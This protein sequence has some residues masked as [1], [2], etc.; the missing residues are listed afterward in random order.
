LNFKINNIEHYISPREFNVDDI[1]Q[2]Y[3]TSLADI[4]KSIVDVIFIHHNATEGF[5]IELH[6]QLGSVFEKHFQ[7]AK[8]LLYGGRYS[9]RMSEKPDFDV[10]RTG[11][12][13]M[14]FIEI[15]FRPNEH[16]D[17]LKFLIGHKQQTLDLGIL[18]VA[19]NRNS[20]NKGYS[21]MPEYKKCVQTIEELQC[22]CPILVMGI[23]GSWVPE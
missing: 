14:I 23:D 7:Y 18:V 9:P 2:T 10:G 19:V 13:K 6:E 16:K 12:S 22:D 4:K 8:W 11:S 21:T 15:E 5:Q 3:G 20:I 1:L 17:I